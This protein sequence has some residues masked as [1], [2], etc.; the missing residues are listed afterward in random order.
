MY[1]YTYIER[2]RDT[3]IYVYIYIYICTAGLPASMSRPWIRVLTQP[4]AGPLPST[5]SYRMRPAF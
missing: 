4:V 1:V 3:Y 2:E 5:S